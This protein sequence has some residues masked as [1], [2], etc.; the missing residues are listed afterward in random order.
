MKFLF[1]I[2]LFF[3]FFAEFGTGWVAWVIGH[4]A[5]RSG[6]LLYF[7]DLHQAGLTQQEPQKLESSSG[8][9]TMPERTWDYRPR[10]GRLL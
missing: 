8:H 5:H 7:G 9:V 4:Q 3:F 10:P 2:S 6:H 1:I